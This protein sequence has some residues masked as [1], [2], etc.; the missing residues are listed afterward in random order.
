MN[1]ENYESFPSILRRI[2]MSSLA[3]RRERAIQRFSVKTERNPAF[4]N[5][6]KLSD[7]KVYDTRTTLPKYKPIQS[8]T[9]RF[10]SSA[11][12]KVIECVS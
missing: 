2:G 11:L 3:V 4:S 10:G 12:P 1:F 9:N 7:S 6:F 8:R 5:W